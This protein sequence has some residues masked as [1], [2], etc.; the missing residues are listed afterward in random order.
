M[1]EEIVANGAWNSSVCILNYNNHCADWHVPGIL[2]IALSK[3][4]TGNSDS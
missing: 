2:W 1:S 4:V 3:Q